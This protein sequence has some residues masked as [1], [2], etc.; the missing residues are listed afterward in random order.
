VCASAP[1]DGSYSL[2]RAQ[3][4]LAQLHQLGVVERFR[5][6]R[7]Q[8]SHP[9]YYLLDHAGALLISSERG[10]EVGELDY[11]RAKTLRL[12]SSQQL[13][14][15]VETNGVVTRL[16]QALRATAGAALLEWWGQRRCA[17]SWGELVRPDAH[18][19]MQLPTGAL[20]LSLEHDRSTENHARLQEK[21]DRYEEL[22]LALEQPLTLLLTL[23]RE[24]RE[25]EARHALRPTGDVLL[26]S[27]TV[28]R[29]H[30][31]P[32]ASNWLP[33][34]GQTRIALEDLLHA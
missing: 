9:Y 4:R 29:H 15:Q 26:L 11:S 27:T 22:A 12:A 30:A 33:A 8:G 1:P 19:R 2:D 6:Y 17:R 24:R 21:L 18:L 25:R 5:P 7:Q 23:T 10:I 28:E 16:A 32:L 31:D 34:A 14:H 20:A 13:R 3:R